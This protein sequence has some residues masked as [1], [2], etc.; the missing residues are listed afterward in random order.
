MKSPKLVKFYTRWN[1]QSWNERHD[2][3]D[4]VAYDQMLCVLS[5][6]P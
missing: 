4:G 5:N 1:F 2:D 6:A 3:N